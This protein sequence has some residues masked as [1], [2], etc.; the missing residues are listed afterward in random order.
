M[1]VQDNISQVA[2]QKKSAIIEKYG[3]FGLILQKLKPIDV[4]RTIIERGIDSSKKAF[5]QENS[6]SLNQ[7]AQAYSKDKCYL[8][9]ELWLYDLNDY[10][11]LKNK[12]SP[13]QVRQVAILFFSE[14]YMLNF[15]EMA[16][17]FNRIKKGYYGDFYGVVDPIKFMG[18]L[19]QFKIERR[20]AIE[21]I[22]MD[23]E[24]L[25]RKQSDIDWMKK[26]ENFTETNLQEISDLVNNFLK[27]TLVQKKKH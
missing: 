10:A 17:F 13:E 4:Q 25:K 24:N 14:A 22:N 16:L 5:L 8:V 3:E 11:G 26:K 20:E 12:M 21:R 23:N 18:F 2:L 1:N 15:T 7:F 6:L 19:N 9:I 27:Q